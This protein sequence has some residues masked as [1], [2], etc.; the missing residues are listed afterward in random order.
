MKDHYFFYSAQELKTQ[1]FFW[2]CSDLYLLTPFFEFLIS[3]LE[4]LSINYLFSDG[5]QAENGL[6]KQGMDYFITWT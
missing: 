5:I 3:I 4:F 1:Q 6:T 2:K